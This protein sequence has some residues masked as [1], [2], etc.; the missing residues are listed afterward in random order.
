M[1]KTP[2]SAPHDEPKA[3]RGGRLRAR[4]DTVKA[5]LARHKLVV[6][7]AVVA[8][9]L[10]LVAGLGL[11]LSSKP[12][13]VATRKTL[14][15]ADA[16]AAFESGDDLKARKLAEF[17]LKVRQLPPADQFWPPYIL[18]VLA[19]RQADSLEGPD[20][21]RFSAVAARY[22]ELAKARNLPADRRPNLLYLLG[23][24]LFHA[25]SQKESL[26]V[27]EEALEADPK[28]PSES[29]R[30]LG[31]GYARAGGDTE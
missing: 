4:L 5:K 17:L 22:L 27:L 9:F 30:L 26:K 15:V 29:H 1:S 21:A 2:K 19:S 18:G 6:I 25:G 14:S 16:V 23:K 11:W 24:N 8:M 31:L 28:Q 12:S 10:P 3:K 20:K 13:R 7:L